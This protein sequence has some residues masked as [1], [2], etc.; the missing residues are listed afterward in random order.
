M[1]HG[2]RY[3]IGTAARGIASYNKP[4]VAFQALR[5]LVGEEAFMEAYR[6]Y[7]DRWTWKHPQ[8]FDMFNTFEDVLGMD[9]DWFWTTLFYE[10]W[11]LDQAISDVSIDANEGIVVTIADNGLS[12]M[13]APVRVTYADG[14]TEEATL[15]VDT[16]MDGRTRSASLTFPAG[17]V[18]KVEI[19]PDRFMPDVD[20]SNNVWE[21]N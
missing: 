1:R 15:S 18:M 2:D 4:A 6:E 3:P 16:W 7:L 11:T 5:G 12:P 20:R 21:A 10:T 8:P 19:D 14:R 13:P 17:A 9:L